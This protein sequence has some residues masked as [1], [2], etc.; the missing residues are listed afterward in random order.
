MRRFAAGLRWRH[1]CGQGL[2]AILRWGLL[3]S[4]PLVG[5][6]WLVPGQLSVALSAAAALLLLVVAGVAVRAYWRGRKILGALR[7]SLKEDGDE[8]A[9]LHD[10]LATWLEIDERSIRAGG[11]AAANG[12]MVQWLERDVHGRLAPYR[13]RALAAVTRPRL[14]RFRWLLPLVLALLLMWLLFAWLV[15]PWSGV[16]GGQPNQASAADQG[17]QG[18]GAGGEDGPGE[19]A[20]DRR[21][22]P[23]QPQDDPGQEEEP[24]KQPDP[25]PLE[26]PKPP[27]EPAEP[28]PDPAEIPPLLELPGDQRFVVPEFIGDG[29]TRRARMRAAELEEQAAG[30]QPRPSGKPR[31]GGGGEVADPRPTPPDFERAAEA[32]QRSRHVPPPER[33]IVRR[34]FERLRA[35]AK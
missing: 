35:K 8:L 23:S 34:F 19:V 16:V 10:E 33:A 24:D 9:M 26:V 15:P 7:Q 21:D 20:P 6:A 5:I 32:A 25:G 17:E 14:G 2:S 30:N 12:E 28:S 3:L 22:A 29:P 13:S 18:D 4:A 27:Q 11:P 31:R 1:V